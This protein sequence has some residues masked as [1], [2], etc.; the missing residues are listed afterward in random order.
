MK[1]FILLTMYDAAIAATGR[2]QQPCSQHRCCCCRA[3]AAYAPW[4][5]RAMAAH[6]L[7]LLWCCMSLTV[8]IVILLLLRT[9]IFFHHVSVV[10]F[11]LFCFVVVWL[12]FL[13]AIF[14]FYFFVFVCFVFVFVFVVASLSSSFLFRSSCHCHSCLLFVCCCLRVEL[15]YAV[16][17][18]VDR[19]FLFCCASCF[20]LF[21]LFSLGFM[22]LF[23][24]ALLL[25]VLGPLFVVCPFFC[26]CHL[27]L[28]LSLLTVV[29]CCWSCFVV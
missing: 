12:L 16:G 17:V 22:C 5:R 7:V 20:F 8:V 28:L 15:F 4:L 19:S 24:C 21:P 13:F 27:S 26:F 23:C 18:F 25:P 29:S 11:R 10:L 6:V 14:L 9:L 3:M 2:I 1:P